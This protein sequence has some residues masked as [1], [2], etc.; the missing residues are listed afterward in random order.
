MWQEAL[1]IFLESYKPAFTLE[2]S[3]HQFSTPEI[4]GMLSRHTGN[5]VQAEELTKTLIDRGFIYTKTGDLTLEWL[6]FNVFQ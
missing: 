4:V 6:M 3:T 2:T 5:E 1:A